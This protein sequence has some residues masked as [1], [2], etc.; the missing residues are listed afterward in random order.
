MRKSILSII[1]ALFCLASFTITAQSKQTLKEKPVLIAAN[2]VQTDQDKKIKKGEEKKISAEEKQYMTSR[3]AVKMAL[4]NKRAADKGRS[5]KSR[6]WVKKA[7]NGFQKR[8]HRLKK[9][10][11]KKKQLK[12]K[13]NLAVN[14]RVKS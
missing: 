10:K 5:T 12:K 2:K 14:P 9:E 11:E 7:P 4:K 6:T 8:Y 3:N 1:C 13:Q